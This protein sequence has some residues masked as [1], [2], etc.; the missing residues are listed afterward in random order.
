MIKRKTKEK[1]ETHI[2]LRINQGLIIQTQLGGFGNRIVHP[3]LSLRVRRTSKHLNDLEFYNEINSV[4]LC[5]K[6]LNSTYIYPHDFSNSLQDLLLTQKL[7]VLFQYCEN[8]RR[9]KC[10]E[11][12]KYEIYDYLC[13]FIRTNLV[14][15]TNWEFI[16][17]NYGAKTRFE[18][19]NHLNYLT[20]KINF[21]SANASI[22]VNVSISS[23]L[24][25]QTDPTLINTRISSVPSVFF[26]SSTSEMQTKTSNA[27][28]Q[29]SRI[30]VS[31]LRALKSHIRRIETDP[32][33]HCFLGLS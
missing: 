16:N 26:K 33:T 1:I 32:L 17:G 7:T 4:V 23:I 14:F 24:G 21:L 12:Q 13:L 19:L 6:I 29:H 10:L 2:P 27:E 11:R 28:L 30:K 25:L 20:Q 9:L 5:T 18:H 22:P 8:L 15:I 3:H 31:T